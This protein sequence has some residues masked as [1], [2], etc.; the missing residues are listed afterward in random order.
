MAE[1]GVAYLSIVPS[2]KNVRR[3]I[4]SAMV[5]AAASASARVGSSMGSRITSGLVTSAKVAG[6]AMTGVL[7]F[8]LVKGFQRLSA[9]ENAKAKLS[10]LG[11][12]A[13]DTSIIMDNALKSVKGTAFGMD[14]AAT[15]AASAV[16]AGIKPGQQLESYLGLVGDAATIAGVSLQDMGGVF[17]KVVTSGKVQGDT[18]QQMSDMGIPV[19]QMLAKTMGVSAEEVYKLGSKG[20]ISSDQF[21]QAMESMR[22]AAQKGGQTTTGAFKNMVAALSRFGAALLSGIYPAIGPVFNTLTSWID[23]ATTAVTPLVEAISKK[24]GAGLQVAGAA[25]VRFVT[26]LKDLMN[27]QVLTPEIVK[28]MGLAPDSPLGKGMTALIGGI[29]A[30]AASWQA[31]DGDVTSSGFAG[32][33][34]RAAFSIHGMWN[35]LKSLDFSSW[36]NF[37]RSLGSGG[38]QIMQQ[39]SSIGGS[40][41]QLGPAFVQLMKAMPGVG[42]AFGGAFVTILKV[43]ADTLAFL[44]R[45]VDTII[46]LIPLIVAGFVVWKGAQQA[47]RAEAEL[48]KRAQLAALPA[49]ITNNGM[50]VV[51]ASL[52]LAQARAT[53]QN[54]IAQGIQNRSMVQGA[55]MRIRSVA[56]MVLHKTATVAMSAASK[57]AAGAQWLL[58]AAMSA[59]PISLIIIGLIALVAIVVVAY[60]RMGWFKDIVNAAW[61]GIKVAIGFVVT[62]FQTHVMPVFMTVL[63]AIGGFFVWLWNNAVKPVWGWIQ[64][65]ISG[66]VTWFTTVAMP[67]IRSALNVLGNVFTWLYNNIIKPVWTGILITV[68]VIAAILVV[69]WKGIVLLV[70]NVLAPIFVW[71]YNTIIVPTW[72]WIKNIINAVAVW[73]STVL[74]PFFKTAINI[75]AG[76]FSWLYNSVIKPVWGAITWF[77]RVEIEGWK[78]IFQ[79]IGNFIST[80]FSAVFRWF[81]DAVIKPVWGAIT[82]FIRTEIEG[83]KRIFGWISDFVRAVFVPMFHWFRDRVRDVFHAVTDV[84]KWA[85]DAIIKPC[86]DAIIGF[87]RSFLVPI[88][89]WLKDRIHDVWQ[90]ISNK[91]RD[92]WNWLRDNVFNPLMNYIKN[93]FVGA[94]NATKDGVAKAWDK[95]KDAVR[96]PIKFVVDTV[97]NKGFIDAYNGINDFW[98]GKD[99]KHMNL[100][101]ATGGYTGRG[102]KYDPAG[103]VHA[104]EYVVKQSSTDRIRREHGLG[105]MDYLN[106]TGDLEG[107]SRMSSKRDSGRGVAAGPGSRVYGGLS[108]FGNQLQADILRMGQL[109]VEP[110]GLDSSWAIQRAAR[111]W[112]GMAGV[113]VDTNSKGSNV[114]RVSAR[115]VGGA[116]WAGYYDTSGIQLNIGQGWADAKKSRPIVA[117]HEIGHALGLPHSM[118]TGGGASIMDYGSMYS[119]SGPSD[120]DAKALQSIYPGGSGKGYSGGGIFGGVMDMVIEKFADPIRKLIEG[121]KKKFGSKNSFAEMPFGV[122]QKML[123]AVVEFAKS[124]L[125]DSDSGGPAPDG[126]VKDWMTKALKMK[127]MFSESNLSLGVRRA[128]QESG[129]NVRAINNWDSNAKAGIPSK[130]LM[131]VIDPTFRSNME[132]GH[133]D[134]WNPID[135]ILASINYTMRQYGSLGAGWGRAGG[136]AEGGLVT[137]ALFDKGGVIKPNSG[138][139]MIDHQRNTPDYVLT[140]QQWDLARRGIESASRGRGDVIVQVKS[141]E[142]EDPTVTGRRAGEALA[143]NLAKVGI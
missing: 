141:H 52:E 134:I 54:N 78:R 69:I 82:W 87:V 64:A 50:R 29:R 42:A 76:F 110:S 40:L 121:Q 97:I 81:Y 143:F 130:G 80:V 111:I 102:D 28:R 38:G 122:A 60:N 93:E 75:F 86:W 15:T 84:I 44:A 112:N 91:I 34:E 72:T 27:L 70:K 90:S 83:W 105:A 108:S 7:G 118:G 43:T 31:M 23:K 10:G 53:Q 100:G 88:F 65:I 12:S 109:S 32:F 74:V 35:S 117:M 73:F 142:G 59:N 45:H 5:P 47:L 57:A 99:L 25:V 120:K 96:E 18:F 37:K 58:N 1:L 85:W 17:G 4:E 119:L 56:S 46:K 131:Q 104:G 129:G 127:G 140:D 92:T 20:Q 101:F 116:P 61:A 30:F 24:I 106:Q 33:M 103:I 123:D 126:A 107:A 94:W 137:P 21:L 6:T 3:Q 41:K 115:Q 68:T 36:D 98:D 49:M 79:W 62:W 48:F 95:L 67:W 124:K 63:H 19:V 22:G 51:A 89:N 16:A 133:G 9:I 71:L 125:G 77:I 2:M 128:M 26:P 132:P 136:Y 14:E 66:F 138:V 13:T 114:P 8:S 113:K 39:L 139:Q 135:N 55:L 11:N